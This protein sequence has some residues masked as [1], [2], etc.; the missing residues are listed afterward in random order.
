VTVDIAARHDFAITLAREA[1][2]MATD[3]RQRMGRLHAK[4][5]MD[6]VTEADHAVES[7]VR[8][9]VA[10]RFG[11]AVIGEENG[12]DAADPVWVVDP[13]D[14]TVNFIHGTPRWCISIALVAQ[15]DVQVGVIYAPV[16]GRL[17]SAMRGHGAYLN[18]APIRVSDLAHG[19]SPVVEVGWSPRRAI[20]SYGTLITRL[21]DGGIEFRRLG[22]GALGLADTACGLN[23]GYLELHINAWDALAGLILVREA[24]GRTNDFLAQDGLISGNPILACTADLATRLADAMAQAGEPVD[25]TP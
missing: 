18:G 23:D 7:L 12:G 9:R 19:A 3:L 13:I 8:L 2:I 22:S 11:D 6:F 21:I 5:P 20:T 25:L 1:G 17:F 24:G 15:G 10:E 14:G 16:E 4:E